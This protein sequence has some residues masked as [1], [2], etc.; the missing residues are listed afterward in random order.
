MFALFIALLGYQRAGALGIAVVLAAGLALFWSMIRSH[1]A[2][3]S[4]DRSTS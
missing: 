1:N 3:N 2:S 4:A